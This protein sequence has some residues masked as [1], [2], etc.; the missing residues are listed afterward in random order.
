M[1]P[2]ILANWKMNPVT[3]NEAENLFKEVEKSLEDSKKAEVIICPP[4]IY[5]PLFQNKKSNIKLGSQDCFWDPSTGGGAFTGE[6]SVLMLKNLNCQYVI[7]GHSERRQFLNEH[8]HLINKKVKAVLDKKLIPILCLGEN[9][10][11]KGKIQTIL[12]KQLEAGLKGIKKDNIE[13]VILA[14]EPVWAIGTGQACSLDEAKIA[15]IFL[16]K[17]LSQ[18]YSR[19][20]AEKIMILYGGSVDSSNA[21]DFI[22]EAGFQGVLVGSASL[23]P[24]EF[25]KLISSI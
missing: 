25:I 8:N 21:Q 13:K 15:R 14:Y 19:S 23:N 17:I 9:K 10:D 2:I 20:I 24:Q 7:I 4:F 18:K 1:K 6:I 5:L 22:K 16:K 11:E 3:T 12:K